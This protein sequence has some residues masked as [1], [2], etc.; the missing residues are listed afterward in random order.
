MIVICMLA[1][2]KYLL[3]GSIKNTMPTKTTSKQWLCGLRKSKMKSQ[4]RFG[5]NKFHTVRKRKK[6]CIK[7][8]FCMKTYKFSSSDTFCKV[9]KGNVEELKKGILETK[10]KNHFGDLL[11]CLSIQLLEKF[12]HLKRVKEYREERREEV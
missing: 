8:H 6:F 12:L 11:V 2:G 9:F 5:I 4:N 10:P 7:L 1:N 3:C